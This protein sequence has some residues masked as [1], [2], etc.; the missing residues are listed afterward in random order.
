MVID[1]FSTGGLDDTATVGS[2]VIRV[3]LAQ[4]HS[5]SH[6]FCLQTREVRYCSKLIRT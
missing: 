2:G 5:L 3:A 4:S 6:C 1:E